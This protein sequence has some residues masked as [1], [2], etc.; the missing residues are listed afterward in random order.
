[1]LRFP[2]E[3]AKDPKANSIIK[4]FING[5]IVAVTDEV[6]RAYDPEGYWS[7]DEFDHSFIEAVQKYFPANYD[8]IKI[9]MKFLGFYALLTDEKEFIPDIVME[10]VMYALIEERIDILLKSGESTVL[11]IP[12]R[13]YV[14]EALRIEAADDIPAETVLNWYEDMQEYY[15]NCFW[16]VDYALLDLYTIDELRTSTMNELVGKGIMKGEEIIIYPSEF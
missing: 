4:S 9:G 2:H 8:R 6:L 14:M 1:M 3:F 13:D 16:D 7:I 10:Y 5:R 15:E 11:A 12:E